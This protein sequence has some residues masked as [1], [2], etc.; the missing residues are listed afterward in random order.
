MLLF[1]ENYPF[2]DLWNKTLHHFQV[3]KKL[4][5]LLKIESNHSIK[6]K[7]I[8]I[9]LLYILSIALLYES[10]NPWIDGLTAQGH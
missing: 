1:L 5:F 2:T 8:Y 7:W 10:I 3:K 4:Q 6:F 9:F